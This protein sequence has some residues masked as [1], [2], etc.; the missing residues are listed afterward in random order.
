MATPTPLERPAGPTARATHLPIRAPLLATPP[1]LVPARMLNEIL[2]CERLFYLE[3]VQGEFQDNAFT[4]EGRFV[5]R[6]VDVAPRKEQKA[7]AKKPNENGDEETDAKLPYETRS[8]W[9]S[10]EQS[11]ITAKLDVLEGAPEGRVVPIEYKRG[12]APDLP[13]GAYLPERAQLCAQVLVL[14]ANGYVVDEAYIYF[15]ASRKRVRIAIDEVLIHQTLEAVA[16]ARIVAAQELPPPPLC[17]SAK[18]HG[19]SL[20]GICLPD[21]TTLLARLDDK[22]VDPPD[23]AP[24]EAPFDEPDPWG[25]TPS[26][27]EQQE[28][29]RLYPARDDKLPVYVQEQ[30][31]RIGLEG[32]RLSVR[33]RAG[34]AIEARLANTTHVALFGNVQ[35]STQALKELVSRGIPVALFTTGA[36]FLGRLV[37]HE[38]KNVDLRIAQYGLATDAP[39]C[40]LLAKGVVSAKIRNARVLLR[41][42]APEADHAVLANLERFA[43]Q[44]DQANSLETLLGIEGTAARSYF[45]EFS[46]MLK[47]SEEQVK[48]FDF[49]GR[50]RRPPRDPVNAMLSFAYALLTKEFA[51]ALATVGL[52]PMLGFYHQPRFG[53]PSL[54]LDLME[55]FRPLLADS[56][57][58]AAINNGVVTSD[59]FVQTGQACAMTAPGRKKVILAYERRMDQLVTHPVFGYKISY[60]RV[61]EVQARLFSRV[62]LG[63]LQQYPHFR[64][65]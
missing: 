65:R 34:G 32:D 61:L 19:C 4:V 64:T 17:D 37:G 41:R 36:Y 22:P 42:N 21:E 16:R 30:G 53:R 44:A 9:L 28:I 59:D 2:Y 26:I 49:D 52:D 51:L 62:L 57:V 29:R 6:R 3:W 56:T 39:R 60:R 38:S 35:V 13:E 43:K 31:A 10:D 1:E 27:A 55:E 14:R 18:C 20:V 48:T 5:H 12:E 8:L 23:E 58:I 24:I 54:A 40:V 50:N 33:G 47:G 7:S 46:S 25:L 11:G 15:A 63:E 45:S